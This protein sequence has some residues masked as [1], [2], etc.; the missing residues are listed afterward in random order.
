MLIRDL[1]VTALVCTLA[2]MLGVLA[3][4]WLQH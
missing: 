1:M 3:F 4:I 2:P